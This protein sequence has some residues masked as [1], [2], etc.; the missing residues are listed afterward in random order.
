MKWRKDLEVICDT[1]VP[2]KLIR[3]VWPQNR[4]SRRAEKY[5][6]YVLVYWE[7][8]KWIPIVSVLTSQ[9]LE[10]FPSVSRLSNSNGVSLLQVPG[11]IN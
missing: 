6:L 11:G 9:Y 3:S 2:L 4:Y 8:Q 1:K 5:R 10:V 7:I